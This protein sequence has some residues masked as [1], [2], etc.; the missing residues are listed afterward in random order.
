[1]QKIR[2]NTLYFSS[3]ENFSLTALMAV[4]YRRNVFSEFIIGP[5]GGKKNLLP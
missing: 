2:I 5:R 4:F 1:M 3:Y